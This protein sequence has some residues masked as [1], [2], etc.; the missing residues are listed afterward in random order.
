MLTGGERLDVGGR[1]YDV[2]YTP[3]HASHHVSYLDAT[4]GIA[5]VGDTAGVRIAGSYIKAPTPP[6]DIDL[7]LW[8]RSLQLFESGA[9][10]LWCSRTSAASM[11]SSDHLRNFA[12]CSSGR[13]GR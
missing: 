4:N 5:Y 11:T 6:P 2:A 1:S 3:G 10:R 8:E 9:P 7:E 12:A 13:R